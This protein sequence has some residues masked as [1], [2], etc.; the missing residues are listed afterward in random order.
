MFQETLKELFPSWKSVKRHEEVVAFT[1]GLMKDP[2]LLV[3]H[4][5]ETYIELVCNSIGPGGRKRENEAD[6]RLQAQG[7]NIADINLFHSLYSKSTVPLFG[8]PGYNQYVFMNEIHEGDIDKTTKLYMFDEVSENPV[9][10]ATFTKNDSS[11][12][13]PVCVL[14]VFEPDVAATKSLL[15]TCC[16]ISKRQPVSCLIMISVHLPHED[17]PHPEKL[18]M[19]KNAKSLHI[20]DCILPINFWKDILHQLSDCVDLQSLFLYI[21]AHQLEEDLDKLLENLE[22]RTTNQLIEVGLNSKYLS[23]KFVKKW[24]RPRLAI[25]CLFD[26]NASNFSDETDE[27]ALDENVQFQKDAKLHRQRKKFIY[28]RKS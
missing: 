11:E 18:T 26:V 10:D 6:R 14:C 9:P 13:P 8:C 22:S 24:N 2:T 19:S 23:Q 4:V 1:C 12:E 7:K 25:K 17:L 28:Q 15:S 27:F 20:T 5:Y 3:N 21:N 16:K